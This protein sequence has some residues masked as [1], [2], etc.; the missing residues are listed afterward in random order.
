MPVLCA[1]EE[2]EK[3][4]QRSCLPFRNDDHTY[5]VVTIVQIFEAEVRATAAE[6]RAKAAEELAASYARQ[7][8][9]IT[10]NKVCSGLLSMLYQVCT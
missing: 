10:D 2:A 4:V 8:Q 7:L 1:Q 3:R 6:V 5:S 9:D